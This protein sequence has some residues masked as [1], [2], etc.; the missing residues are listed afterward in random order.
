MKT[1]PYLVLLTLLLTTCR[2]T[3]PRPTESGRNIFACLV[4]GKRWVP[5]G[6]PGFGGPKPIQGGFAAH[7][8]WDQALQKY[9][10]KIFINIT[11]YKQNGEIVNIYCKGFQAG[12]YVLNTTTPII[13]NT[14]YPPS[15]GAFANGQGW[16]ITNENNTGEIHITKADTASGIISGTFSFKAALHSNL[17]KTVEITNGR[18]DINVLTL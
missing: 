8:V 3:L 2:F 9:V 18:F 6:G 1:L 15:Y 12:R 5:D 4:D 7:G 16:F 13:P 10:E 17:S 11:A 14:R